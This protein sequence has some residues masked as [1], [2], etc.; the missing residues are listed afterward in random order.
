MEKVT[1]P[2][3]A[4]APT[5]PPAVLGLTFAMM[6]GSPYTAETVLVDDT[7]TLVL[8]LLTVKLGVVAAELPMMLESELVYCAEVTVYFPTLRPWSRRIA[9]VPDTGT[10]GI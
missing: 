3:S 5:A 9:D 6:A 2:V 7:K 4:S 8:S 10:T 1:L